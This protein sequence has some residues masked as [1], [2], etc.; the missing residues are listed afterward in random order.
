MLKN[1]VKDYRYDN[2][3]NEFYHKSFP[4]NGELRI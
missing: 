4:E 3:T 2:H 1:G